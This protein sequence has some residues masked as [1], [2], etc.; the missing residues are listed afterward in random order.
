MVMVLFKKSTH[1]QNLNNYLFNGRIQ[2][3]NTPIQ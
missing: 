3:L 2:I 1:Q